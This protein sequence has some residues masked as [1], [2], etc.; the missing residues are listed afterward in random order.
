M[1]NILLRS[2]YYEYHASSSAL[3]AKMELSINGV[4]EY[5]I[6]KDV[7]NGGVLFEISELVRDFIEITYSGSYIEQTVAV[8]G[9]ITFYDSTS[10]SGNVIGT[11]TNFS[12]VGFDGYST[13]KEGKNFTI[14]DGSLLQSN[15]IMYVPE[16]TAG[17]IPS[18]TGG[19]VT[20]NT[21]ST[22]DTSATIE[23]TAISIKRICDTKYTP[24]KVTFV[25]KFGV[26]Q[27]IWFDKKST[28]KFSAGFETYKRN[29]I[30][31]DGSYSTTRHQKR[32]SNYT[33]TQSITMNTGFIDEGMNEVLDQ[34]TLSEYIWA[35]IDSQVIPLIVSTKEITHK[36]AVNDRLINY[37]I[38]FEY[39]YEVL[40]NIR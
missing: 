28:Q 23:S 32:T 39:A 33:S 29:I 2:P 30:E 18:L 11:P 40:N 31:L 34:L 26:L 16:N 3:S 19:D 22:S 36:T 10:G 1:A 6:V 5:T 4:L 9:T 7:I 12:H 15:T 24:I 27:D 8:T 14:S 37:T 20:Y 25:N 35:T 13:F 21:F 17:V 38:D